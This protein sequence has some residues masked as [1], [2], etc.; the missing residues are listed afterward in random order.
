MSAYSAIIN[1]SFSLLPRSQAEVSEGRSAWK[2]PPSYLYYPSSSSPS[3]NCVSDRIWASPG[4]KHCW[5]C[6]SSARAP[7][8]PPLMPTDPSRAA[9]KEQ[10]GFSAAG[11][12]SSGGFFKLSVLLQTYIPILDGCLFVTGIRH[13]GPGLASTSFPLGKSN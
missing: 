2:R 10:G 3:L 13:R 12:P 5:G 4:R 7:W 8:I 9:V 11:K 1:G 6:S